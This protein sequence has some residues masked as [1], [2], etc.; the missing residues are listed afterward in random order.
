MRYSPASPSKAK[1]TPE[2]YNKFGR[3]L[4]YSSAKLQYLVQQGI[5]RQLDDT[6]K[7]VDAIRGEKS[8]K[9]WADARLRSAGWAGLKD[10]E[11]PI[12]EVKDANILALRN[13]LVYLDKLRAGAKLL[14]V[15]A[16]FAKAAGMAGNAT[17]EHNM[18]RA[19]TVTATRVLSGD[20]EMV[21]RIEA[22]MK[23]I[24]GLPELSPQQKAMEY[25]ERKY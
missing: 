18:Q 20:D 17:V 15:Q 25:L 10:P 23:M 24:E 3:W 16:S 2:F 13:Q 14:G 21:E 12:G 9:G 4:D 19:M 22:A 5:G 6:I 7:L 11:F 1:Q 8:I